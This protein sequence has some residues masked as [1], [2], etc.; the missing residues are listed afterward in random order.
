MLSMAGGLRPETGPSIRITRQIEW[1][2]I[3]VQGA[4]DDPTGKF[5]IAEVDLKPLMEAKSPEK[6]I[7][8]RPHDVIS[9]PRAEVVYV[10]GE[11]T[12]VGPLLLTDRHT[13]SVL[14]A[15]SSSGGLLRTGAPN[16]AK[17]LRLA[18]GSPKVAELPIDLKKILNG[19][20]EDQQLLAGDVLLV[21]GSASKRAMTR[22]LEAAI[23]SGTLAATYGVVR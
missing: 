3:P 13:M 1:G 17:I 12:K 20:A 8:I 16:H 19:K 10:I 22:V 7:L 23:Q 18:Q 9:V 5:S 2:R 15:V 4:A 21:P 14:Q 11:V 6:N